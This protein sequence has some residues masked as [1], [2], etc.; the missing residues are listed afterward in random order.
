MIGLTSKLTGELTMEKHLNFSKTAS[1]LTRS[2]LAALAAC[3]TGAMILSFASGC[4]YSGANSSQSSSGG[5]NWSS[6]YRA[7]V[8]TIAVPQFKTRSFSRGDELLLTQALVTAI[9]RKTPYKVVDRSRAD[10]S[11]EGEVVDV[12]VGTVSR[13]RSTALPQEQVY[14]LTV[15]F[16]WTDLR[17]GRVLVERKQFTQASSYFPTMGEGRALGKQ[18]SVEA[19]AVGIVEQLQGEW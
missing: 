6:T 2:P 9:E 13:D 3:A 18:N 1:S 11:L 7:D 10:T 8:R 12:S 15:D 14:T 5:Y 19:L 16:T 4:G 17:S